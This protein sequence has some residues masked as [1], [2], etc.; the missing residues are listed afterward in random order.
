[1]VLLAFGFGMEAVQQ[2]R[3]SHRVMCCGVAGMCGVGARL[4][5]GAIWRRWNASGCDR[6]MWQGWHIDVL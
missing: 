3:S 2:A 1:M 5:C 4:L 6:E